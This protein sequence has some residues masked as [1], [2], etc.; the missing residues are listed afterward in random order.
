MRPLQNI[1]LAGNRVLHLSYDFVTTQN[2]RY[3]DV[4]KLQ[5]PNLVC[6]HQFC[7]RCEEAG[8]IEHVCVQC[9]VRKHLF[10]E[11]PVGSML[12]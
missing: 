12:S 2:T 10:W 8:D 9:G 5:V 6:L 3:S 1:L 7:S 4:A 11:Y